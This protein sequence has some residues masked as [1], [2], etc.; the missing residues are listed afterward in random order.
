MATVYKRGRVW[1]A[2]GVDRYGER[3]QRSTK[4]TDERAAKTVAAGLE[5]ELASDANRPRDEACTLETILE[6]LIVF[7]KA[8]GR[9]PKTVEFQSTKARHLARVIGPRRRA[10]AITPALTSEYAQQRIKEGAHRHTVSFEVRVLM[11]ALRRAA[12][13][14][15]FKPEIEVRELKPA[16][17]TGAY[18]PRDRWLTP[19]EYT[20]LLAELDPER[21]GRTRRRRTKPSEAVALSEDVAA[22]GRLH[23]REHWDEQ[24]ARTVLLA[25]AHSG[26]PMRS[27]ARAHG[28]AVQRMLWWRER[29]NLTGEIETLALAARSTLDRRDLEEDRRDYLVVMCQTGARL[30]ELHGIEAQHVDLRRRTLFIAGTKT[31]KARRTVPITQAVADAL[32]Q[33]M[34]RFPRG[35]LFPVWGKVQR[36]L[37]AACLRIEKRSNPVPNEPKAK[38]KGAGRKKVVNQNPKG[39]PVPKRQRVKPENAFDPVTP[40]DLRRT[41]ASWLAQAGVPMLHAMKLMGHGSTQM[42]ERVYAQLAPEHLKEAV[43]LLPREVTM[44]TGEVA[45]NRLAR[46]ASEAPD[47]AAMQAEI[48][49]LR[50]ELEA[51]RDGAIVVPAAAIER[52]SH[53]VPKRTTGVRLGRRL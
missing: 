49:R 37:Y 26:E 45:P 42:L 8:S 12:K 32:E 39:N 31:K 29:L 6:D 5:E 10:A 41:Y 43:A 18:Q 44:V 2:A 28:F 9:S 19:A 13:L 33:R 22:L 14:R 47:V 1:W 50:G 4:Q 30:K 27:F 52:A 35:P 24:T 23:G 3:W 21:G 38:G 16:E 11:Q 36:D 34:R 48:E 7:S 20:L 40:N 53:R 15:K 46:S 17:L 25:W 51:A